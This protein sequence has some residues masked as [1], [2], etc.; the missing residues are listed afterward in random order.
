MSD[1][2]YTDTDVELVA[3]ASASRR[4]YS[5]HGQLCPVWVNRPKGVQTGDSRFPAG[6]E[7]GRCDCWIMPGAR[8]KARAVLDALTAAGWRNLRHVIGYRIPGDILLAPEDVVIVTGQSIT[9]TT[10]S[11][12]LTMGAEG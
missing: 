1:R 12:L 7:L 5:Q 9:H 10:G 11:P 4:R 3:K 8:R 2:P 6:A